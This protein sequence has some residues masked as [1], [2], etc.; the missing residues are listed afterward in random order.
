MAF[1]V[2]RNHA[3]WLRLGAAALVAGGPLLGCLLLAAGSPALASGAAAALLL[4][5]AFLERWLFFAQA[6]H[7]VTLYY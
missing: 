5:G 2:A 1:Q 7:V 4:A 6:R 3:R